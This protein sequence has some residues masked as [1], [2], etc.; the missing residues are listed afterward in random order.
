MGHSRAPRVKT[1]VRIH[2]EVVNSG[3][4][5]EPLG[6]R[7]VPPPKLRIA[8]GEPGEHGQ[9]S[10]L[11]DLLEHFEVAAFIHA[12]HRLGWETTDCGGLLDIFL[13]GGMRC[14]VVLTDD[15]AIC[16]R[17]DMHWPVPR[18]TVVTV[19]EASDA[20]VEGA[21]MSGADWVI[22]RP[23]DPQDPLRGFA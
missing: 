22:Q 15:P 3:P 17:L 21:W 6:E 18:P 16:K 1:A 10:I 2:N 4:E 20:A 5:P 23:I 12:F 7:R 8:L 19:V 11:V 14:D 13:A 9:R